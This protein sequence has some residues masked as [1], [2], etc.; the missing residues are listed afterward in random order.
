MVGNSKANDSTRSSNVWSFSDMIE[1]YKTI[2]RAWI[3]QMLRTGII[4]LLIVSS[5]YWLKILFLTSDWLPDSRNRLFFCNTSQILIIV[6]T[7]LALMI[8]NIHSILSAMKIL[9]GDMSK[10]YSFQNKFHNFCSIITTV[11]PVIVIMAACIII[12]T[13]IQYRFY[14]TFLPFFILMPF[15]VIIIAWCSERYFLVVPFFLFSKIDD[16][17]CSISHDM[18]DSEMYTDEKRK[19]F[20]ELFCF[21]LKYSLPVAVITW[22]LLSVLD[23][24]IISLFFGM[25]WTTVSLLSTATSFLLSPRLIVYSLLIGYAVTIPVIS[26]SQ[27]YNTSQLLK[28]ADTLNVLSDTRKVRKVSPSPRIILLLLILLLPLSIWREQSMDTIFLRTVTGGN[29]SAVMLVLLHDANVDAYTN[30]GMNSLFIS[31][32]RK[33]YTLTRI[34]LR[35][36]AD[37][38]CCD[39]IG[40]SPLY[41]SVVANLTN[42]AEDYI[43]YGAQINTKDFEGMSPL[44]RAVDKKNIAMVDILLQ[45]GAD[46]N[47]KSINSITP[48]Y[49]A[50]SDGDEAISK[51]LLQYRCNPNIIAADGHPILYIAVAKR[52]NNIAKLLID[53]GANVN[54]QDNYGE[55]SLHQAIN[56]NNKEITDLLLLHGAN[57]NINTYMLGNTP[58]HMACDRQLYDMIKLLISNGSNLNVY[59]SV[60]D[61]PLITTLRSTFANDE[62]TLTIV[63]F[64]LRHD[65]DLN[66]TDRYN[67]NA[68]SMARRKKFTRISSLLLQHGARLPKNSIRT[69]Y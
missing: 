55:T 56:S 61:T 5:T 25:H 46:V 31:L 40:R 43:Q 6:A 27:V 21:V 12:L 26:F 48:I 13:G 52:F 66:V 22:L 9:F 44:H 39:H 42:F 3:I 24:Y 37:V 51:H 64:L 57:P 50:V 8:L 7:T 32:I 28:R 14:H 4:L 38:T 63:K 18:I 10:Q 17:G 60:G 54:A 19:F 68:L 35:D 62:T 11:R 65:A 53:H 1:A 45:S 36:G 2:N 33:D 47:A 58:L 67:E 49:I 59:N 41:Y 30:S 20:Q 69:L 15:C 23:I 29:P 16:K 34:L